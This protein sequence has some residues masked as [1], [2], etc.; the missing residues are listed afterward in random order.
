M[1]RLEDLRPQFSSLSWAEKL[2]FVEDYRKARLADLTEI[3]TFDL[4]K[5][6]REKKEKTAKEKKT[7]TKKKLDLSGMTQEQLDLL[8]KLGIK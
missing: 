2:Q 3:A 6:K 1:A 4:S 7:V 5:P 8:A